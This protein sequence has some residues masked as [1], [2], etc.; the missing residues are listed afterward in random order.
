MHSD[1]NIIFVIQIKIVKLFL[2][3]VE[4]Y[5]NNVSSSNFSKE[6]PDKKR[7]L[8]EDFWSEDDEEDDFMLS[9][10]NIEELQSQS[11]QKQPQSIGINTIIFLKNLFFLKKLCLIKV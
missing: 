9:Q 6:P 5:R 4:M 7:K 2:F 10:I 11:V 1:V 3:Q 8:E